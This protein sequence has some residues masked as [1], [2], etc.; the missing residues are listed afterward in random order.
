MTGPGR[1][2]L[3]KDSEV[4]SRLKGVV[5]S[6]GQPPLRFPPARDLVGVALPQQPRK[7]RR[8]ANT[9]SES[10]TAPPRTAVSTGI[11][12]GNSLANNVPPP[13][14]TELA[15]LAEG[16]NA[17]AVR[18][19][20]ASTLLFSRGRT[21]LRSPRSSEPRPLPAGERGKGVGG[22]SGINGAARSSGGAGGAA[23]CDQRSGGGAGGRG[24]VVEDGLGAA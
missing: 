18:G 19:G 23:L 24:C 17:T 2:P 20:D 12:N 16:A 21:G 6:A 1:P 5:S 14:A 10:S 11:E 3:V 7:D 13:E 8:S 22:A 4:Q 15:G 9:S